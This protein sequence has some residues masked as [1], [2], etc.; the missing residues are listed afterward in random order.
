VIRENRETDAGA[1]VARATIRFNKKQFTDALAD[2]S[3]AILIF[4]KQ[5]GE[6]EAKAAADDKKD[7]QRKAA[8]E[9]RRK[10]SLEAEMQRAAE[11]RKTLEDR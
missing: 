7:R 4:Q 8:S 11:S 3:H 6:L 1:N 2:Y 5:I 10:A 9:R